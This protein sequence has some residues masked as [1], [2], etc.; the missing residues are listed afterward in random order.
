MQEMAT[1]IKDMH[2]RGAGL[3]G[4]SAACGMYLAAR[5]AP[6]ELGA[7]Q[8]IEHMHTAGETLKAT[9]PTAANLEWAVKRQLA[10]LEH[11]ATRASSLPFSDLLVAEMRAAAR[12][13][14][15]AILDEDS[16]WC[17]SIGAPSTTN[18]CTEYEGKRAPASS[19][20]GIV[21]ARI[22]AAPLAKP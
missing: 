6:E 15:Q 17:E 21:R 8:F 4:A 10:R 18:K 5:E 2:V 20:A 1:A 22:I 11:A 9:R 3:V 19:I 16:R 13:E 14:A 7:A 12:E